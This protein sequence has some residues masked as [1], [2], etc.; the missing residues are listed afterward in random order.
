M[1]GFWIVFVIRGIKNIPE[2]IPDVLKTM[3]SCNGLPPSHS[4]PSISQHIRL[5]LSYFKKKWRK[6]N[7]FM[8]TVK[9][10]TNASRNCFVF[11]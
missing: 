11:I 9:C 5:E 3:P 8:K 4:K 2:L 7:Y 10:I 1:T 6:F